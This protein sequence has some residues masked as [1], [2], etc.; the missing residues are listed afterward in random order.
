MAVRRRKV[1][2]ER[3]NKNP[4]IGGPAPARSRKRLYREPA[5][6]EIQP[7]WETNDYARAAGK[8]RTYRIQA[9]LQGRF[10][11]SLDGKVLKRGCDG[12]AIRGLRKPGPEVQASS[13]R[14]A[15]VA[16][17]YLLGMTEE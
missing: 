14:Q 11:I 7:M 12:L 16:I 6:K 13:I 17:D 15:K 2:R 4:R 9:D 5:S 10:E 8:R 3:A 1:P